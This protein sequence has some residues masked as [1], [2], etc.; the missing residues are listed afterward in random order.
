MAMEIVSNPIRVC[1]LHVLEPDNPFEMGEFAPV[2]AASRELHAVQAIE[3]RLS[4]PK[5]EQVRV[6]VVMD[7]AAHGIA[8]H[9]EKMGADLIVMPSHGRTGLRRAL[10]GSVTERVVRLAHCPVLVLRQ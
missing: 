3:E 5:Y 10:V 4:D 9:A 6:K 1:V 7:S 8:D 2:D